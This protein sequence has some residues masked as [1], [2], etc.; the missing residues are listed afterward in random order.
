[1][2]NDKE[3]LELYIHV[4]RKVLPQLNVMYDV[5]KSALEKANI[6][7]KKKIHKQIYDGYILYRE[8]VQSTWELLYS[9]KEEYNLVR[10][11]DMV[12]YEGKPALPNETKLGHGLEQLFF[13]LDT[14]VSSIA[15]YYNGKMDKDKS[16]KLHDIAINGMTEIMNNIDRLYNV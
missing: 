3:V 6:F 8:L 9:S 15:L 7:N 14:A 5:E 11:S 1:M 16:N 12:M 2:I 13:Y 4:K 10:N